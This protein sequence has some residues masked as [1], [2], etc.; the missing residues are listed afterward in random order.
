MVGYRS[1]VMVVSVLMLLGCQ[2]GVESSRYAVPLPA[3]TTAIST[4]QSSGGDRNSFLASINRLRA[5]VG[6]TPLRWSASLAQS[7]Q[8]YANHLATLGRVE[9]GNSRYGENLFFASRASNYRDAFGIWSAEERNYD[10]LNRA[11]QEGRVCG[12]YTQL[13]WSRTKEMGCGTAS[14]KQ[15]RFKGGSVIVCRFYPRGN[16]IGYRAY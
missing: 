16:Q 2:R 1:A 11:C 12:H 15:G 6:T 14:I 7:S 5:K 10:H 13:V 8:A 4:T 3:S 9:H